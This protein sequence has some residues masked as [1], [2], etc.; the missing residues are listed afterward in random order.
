MWS[1]LTGGNRISS[2]A[3]SLA[4]GAGCGAEWNS[5]MLDCVKVAVNQRQKW[6]IQTVAIVN[7]A[8]TK[9]QSPESPKSYIEL[10]EGRKL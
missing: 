1:R 9:G 3:S 4:A 8:D 7:V 5:G 2:A 10:E 6:Y